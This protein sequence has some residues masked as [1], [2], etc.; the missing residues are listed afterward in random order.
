MIRQRLTGREAINWFTAVWDNYA[1]HQGLPRLQ[2]QKGTRGAEKISSALVM[3]IAQAGGNA[4]VSG[5][6]KLQPFKQYHSPVK[7]GSFEGD[8]VSKLRAGGIV[9]IDL[10]Q[11]DPKLRP[12]TRRGSAV[13]IFNDGMGRFIANENQNYIQLYSRRRTTF[14]RRRMSSDLEPES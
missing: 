8:I 10:S 2:E 7:H 13:V 12:R 1:S 9:I 6:G 14:F 11:G 5:Y 3:L 4:D